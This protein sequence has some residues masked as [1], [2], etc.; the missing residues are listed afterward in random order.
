[1]VAA[2]GVFSPAVVFDIEELNER[3]KDNP[4]PAGFE[5]LFDEVVLDQQ[6]PDSGG[7]GSP[8][9][10]PTV[11]PWSEFADPTRVLCLDR[12]WHHLVRDANSST[13]GTEESL[14]RLQH[15]VSIVEELA[16]RNPKLTVAVV[17]CSAGGFQELDLYIKDRRPMLYTLDGVSLGI[18]AH[19]AYGALWPTL[20]LPPRPTS[21]RYKGAESACHA[22]LVHPVVG[23]R[24]GGWA[25]FIQRR[26][27]EEVT[28]RAGP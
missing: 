9:A 17:L 21:G 16:T 11:N 12:A 26:R 22:P 4:M 15:Y 14:L 8:A 18:G 24:G 6:P 13:G 1:M 19:R 25:S 7:S 23:I 20:R 10:A 5:Q 2:L 3:L 28:L 27:S